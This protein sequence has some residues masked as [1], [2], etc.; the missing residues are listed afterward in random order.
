MFKLCLNKATS[1]NWRHR[2]TPYL[3]MNSPNQTWPVANMLYHK[4]IKLLLL[5]LNDKSLYVLFNQIF[6]NG[7]IDIRR[8]KEAENG[9]RKREVFYI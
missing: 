7:K 9:A 4:K 8:N 2:N 6:Y 1:N 5:L 3:N